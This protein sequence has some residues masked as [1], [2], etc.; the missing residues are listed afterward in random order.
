M[1]E[2]RPLF[3]FS[4]YTVRHV[5]VICFTLFSYLSRFWL[6]EGANFRT[7]QIFKFSWLPLSTDTYRRVILR[8]PSPPSLTVFIQ[9]KHFPGIPSSIYTY[10]RV[11]VQ[12]PVPLCLS[13]FIQYTLFSIPHPR[14]TPIG[15]W[16]YDFRPCPV[17][18]Y[19]Y[20]IKNSLKPT[21]D[22]HLPAS[23]SRPCTV[24]VCS[25]NIH[26]FLFLT[27]DGHLPVS[28]G[29]TPAPTTFDCV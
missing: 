6:L 27:L 1:Q 23:D 17:W 28:V 4:F 18:M 14:W 7:D 25:Y 19:S 2:D 11:I 26:F 13:V 9:Y 8:H 15:E 12:L 29:T 5:A 20:S 22:G 3:F 24:W 10:W 21:P 16:W